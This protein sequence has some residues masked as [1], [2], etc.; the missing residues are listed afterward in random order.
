[1]ND[2]IELELRSCQDGRKRS[3]RR[4]WTRSRGLVRSIAAGGRSRDWSKRFGLGGFISERLLG[5]D[6]KIHAA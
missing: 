4:K 6:A 5:G 1:V 3:R 2:E